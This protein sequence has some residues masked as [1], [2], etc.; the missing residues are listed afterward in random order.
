MSEKTKGELLKEQLV[1][2]NTDCFKT[3]SDDE[4]NKA[5]EFCEGYKNYLNSSKTERESVDTALKMLEYTGFKP[6]D[7]N[8]S[9]KA[10]DKVYYNNRGRALITAVIGKKAISEGVQII[11][12]HI[13]SPRLDLK[14]VPLYEE[15]NMA[16]LKTHHYGGVKKYQWLSLPLALHGV[17]VKKSGEVIKV[18]IG[19]AEHEPVFVINDLLIH[20]AKDQ[21]AKNMKDAVPGESLNVLV[22]GIPFKDDKVSEKVKLN[23][24]AMLFDK[25]QMV[26][27]DFLSSELMLVPAFKA[28]D[29]GLDRSFVG[30]YGHDDRV[31]AYTSIMATIANPEPEFTCLTVL[32]DK[33]ETG[34][35][36]NT[37]LDS[38]MISDFVHSLAK[39]FGEDGR[40]VLNNSRCLSADVNGAFD[41]N[42]G[43]VYEKRNSCFVNKGTV[44]SKYTGSGG[45]GGTNDAS[46]EFMGYV[47][48]MLEDN[49]VVWQ[50]GELGKIDQGGG[51][52]VA[53]F[54]SQLGA[55]V[56][57]VGV[58]VLGMHSPYEVVAK[59]DVYNTYKAFDAFYKMK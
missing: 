15:S 17:I 6:F 9:Y 1:Y 38:T 14:P 34:S 20:L 35:N 33:E 13:D 57:D 58:P 25:Y 28:K 23:I 54:I 3:M 46:A 40:I 26:E 49:N 18:S 53:M 31:C 27:A 41:P 45:K 39:G 24:L 5:F 19:E 44:I 30:S 43:E 56:V 12:S 37:G 51:G 2:E 8:A 42:Y 55:D 4:I 36:G 48:A 16:Y 59:T 32:S 7:R 11:A 47:R 10:G 52:T 22:G 50:I 21:M 29:V